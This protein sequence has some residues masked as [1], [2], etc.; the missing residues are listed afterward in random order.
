MTQIQSTMN[1][2]LFQF[3]SCNRRINPNHVHALTSDESFPDHFP[4]HPIIVNE[5]ME[6]VDGQ[7][8][9]EA[10]KYLEIPIYYIIQDGADFKT[11]KNINVNQKPWKNDDYLIFYSH[12]NK[13]YSFVFD[14][15]HRFTIGIDFLLAVIAAIEDIPRHKVNDQF[16]RGN[17][18]LKSKQMVLEFLQIF[19]PI[20]KE[21][22]KNSSYEIQHL[23]GR[24]YA[25]E[26][27]L[28]FRN[29]IYDFKKFI[30]FFPTYYK[31]LPYCSNQQDCREKVEA[32]SRFHSKSTAT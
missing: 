26:I 17:L 16:K 25:Y 30:S 14:M 7:H 31:K 10:A 22:R 5:K 1:Y 4:F 29:K 8:R 18:K 9:F 6:I 28:L 11:I 23:F 2:D 21:T 12:Q 3:F 32:L 19:I 13:D 24:I 20:L 27:A 15:K